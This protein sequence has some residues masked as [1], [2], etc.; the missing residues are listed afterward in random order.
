MTEV[1]HVQEDLGYV[2]GLVDKAEPRSPAAIYLLWA[3]IVLA[4]FALVDFAPK[5]T[6][7][8]WLIAGPVGFVAS[9]V[10]GYRASRRQGQVDQREGARHVLHW[11][12]MMTAILLTIPLVLTGS[13]TEKGIGQVILLIV[14]LSYFLNGVH[15]DRPL[16]WIGILMAAGYLAT[17][18]VS[19]Y[20]WTLL[21]VMIAAALVASALSGR[22]R[23]AR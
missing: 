8:F 1:K 14:A 4:G 5:A 16:L 9:T 22:A 10:I 23:A 20:V 15:L 7:F 13:V 21:G 12:G 11:G 19:K 3:P 18:V 17:F 6:G 2:R